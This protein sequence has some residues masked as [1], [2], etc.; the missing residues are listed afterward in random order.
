MKGGGFRFL[1]CAIAFN[2][3]K[4]LQLPR[5]KLHTT[6][7]SHLFLKSATIS[8]QDL[9]SIPPKQLK[10]TATNIRTQKNVKHNLYAPKHGKLGVHLSYESAIE[11]LQI[12]Y[13]IHNHLVIPRRYVV[14]CN[15]GKNIICNS[16]KWEA[17]VLLRFILSLKE[18][19]SDWH[20]VDLSGTVYNMNWWT[21]HVKSRP[22]RVFELNQLGFVWE[23]LQPEWNLVLEALVTYH[24]IYGHTKVP[25]SFIVPYEKQGIWPKATWGIALG[26]CVYRIRS[27]A[28]FLRN[29]DTC[30][31]RRQQL[32]G[33]GFIWD[34]NEHAF[35]KFFNALR[36][37]LKLKE[38]ESKVNQGV[39]DR[40]LRVPSTFIVPSGINMDD[41]KNP[42][43]KYLWGYPLGAKCGAVRQKELYIKNNAERKRALQEIGFQ[44]NGN[45]T[46]GWLRVVHAA[47]IYSKM[48][49]RTLDVPI[50]F[51][52]PSPHSSSG[53]ITDAWPWPGKFSRTTSKI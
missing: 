47:A 31:S 16:L 8:E 19:P 42:W 22:T 52:V 24:S 21:R 7:V 2:Q 38:N 49:N 33:L 15:K 26:N 50:S 5:V 18:F 11:V 44:L 17:H 35:Q 9:T 32:D 39:L 30:W 41:K 14:P 3:A 29:E 48:H 46:L 51:R 43:P 27:R 45:A 23:R 13:G 53:D 25:I 10:Y 34:V 4:S 6:R 28:D 1:V 37:F 12:Y 36:F 20:N 40:A